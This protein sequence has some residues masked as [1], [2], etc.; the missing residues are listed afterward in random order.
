MKKTLV[1]LA[2]ISAFAAPAMAEEASPLTFN[3]GV[4]SDY[5]FRGISQTQHQ[6]AVQGG[7]DYAHS[8]GLY[9]GAW[10]STVEWVNRK[11]WSYQK[12]NKFEFDLY[13]GYKNTVGGIGYDVGMIR[14]YY[15]GKF[16]GD[17]NGGPNTTANTTEA[18]VGLTYGIATFKYSQA[19]TSFMGWGY[20]APSRSSKGS[21]YYDL[22]VTYPY[23]E[24]VNVIA[25]IGRQD[26]KN[27]N[28]NNGQWSYT[29]Y[30]LGVTKDIGF[31]VVGLTYTATNAAYDA[32]SPSAN[33]AW[34]S[35]NVGKDVFAL[36]F[37]KNF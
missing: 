16:Q 3:V 28:N 14:Y 6:P 12:D 11:D 36:S 15:P 21:A 7:V 23:N 30:K 35:K 9:V 8:S 10:G 34:A 33:Y 1:S 5:V 27:D 4:V 2:L 17:Y 22:T 26:V 24:T 25:H 18:Y 13:G 29:D 31:G 19:L 37:L 32:S 20:D